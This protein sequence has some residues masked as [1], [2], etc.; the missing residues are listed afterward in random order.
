MEPDLLVARRADLTEKNLPSAPVLAIE[1]LTPST[2][3]LD[4]TLKR[5][6]FETAGCPSCW[7]VDPDRPAVIAWELSDGRYLQVAEVAGDEEFVADLPYR[8]RLRPSD[9][10]R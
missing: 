3:R 10:V 1:V 5:A 4:L 7:V 9:L 8:V 6:R 2:R